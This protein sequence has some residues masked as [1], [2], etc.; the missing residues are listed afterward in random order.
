VS[1]YVGASLGFTAG[2][3][4]ARFLFSRPWEDCVAI[5]FVGLFSNSVLLGI[6]ITER[7]YGDAVLSSTFSIIALHA[8]FCYGLGITVMEIVRADGKGPL[9]I[10]RAAAVAMFRNTLILAIA[11]G[12]VVNLA[13]WTLPSPVLD[14]VGIIASAA[15]P[16]ALFGLGG[17]L[18]SYRPEGDIRIVLYL[19]AV[20]LILHP[21]MAFALAHLF[22]LPRDVLRAAVLT[23]AMAPGVNSFIFANMYGVGRRVAATTVLVATA[24]SILTIWIWLLVLP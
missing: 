21:A 8:P 15:L 18:V 4:G 3:L 5:G 23:G 9:G 16:T 13:G 10:A 14:A 19:C 1:F 24:F 20:S 17:V 2:L 12:F 6:P 11:L 22:E 7:A